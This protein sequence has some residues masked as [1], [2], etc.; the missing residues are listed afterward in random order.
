ML[1]LVPSSCEPAPQLAPIPKLVL[2]PLLVSIP[3]LAPTLQL[4]KIH[5]LALIPQLAPIPQPVLLPQLAPIPMLAPIPQPVLLP[6][7]APTPQP[8]PVLKLTHQSFTHPFAPALAC[9]LTRHQPSMNSLAP[10]I[11]MVLLEL[12]YIQKNLH[13]VQLSPVSFALQQFYLSR[14]PGLSYPLRLAPLH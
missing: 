8:A 6:Q 12:L 9:S 10:Q 3:Q 5:Q 4:A 14:E 7:L 2:L 1:L 13:I 11:Q